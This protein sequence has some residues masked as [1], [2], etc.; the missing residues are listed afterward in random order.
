MQYYTNN[1][2]P[3]EEPYNTTAW[4]LKRK[5]ILSRDN[6]ECQECFNNYIVEKSRIGEILKVDD[7]ISL[8]SSLNM[9]DERFYKFGYKIV[10]LDDLGKEYSQNILSH[11]RVNYFEQFIGCKLLL[12]NIRSKS[13]E[14]AFLF[15]SL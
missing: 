5:R 3:R 8:L 11:I 1:P 13:K 14:K 9:S 6:L 2:Y 15:D 10:Y 7:Y 12:C 4:K